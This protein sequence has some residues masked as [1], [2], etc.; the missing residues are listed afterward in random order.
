MIDANSNKPTSANLENSM[1]ESMTP[2]ER[3]VRLNP[4]SIAPDGG[5]KSFSQQ[6]GEY[7]FKIESL[8]MKGSWASLSTN[9]KSAIV[10]DYTPFVL[11][12]DCKGFGVPG[13]ERRPLVLSART[14]KHIMD[15]HG[16]D[17]ESL[18]SNL[19]RLSS[20][21][22]QNILACV[23]K[24]HEN[25]INFILNEYSRNGNQML[26]AVAIDANMDAIEVSSIRSVHGNSHLFSD[27]IKSAVNGRPFFVN[28]RTG[29]WLKNQQQFGSSPAVVLRRH[30]LTFYYTHL[31]AGDGFYKAD[32]INDPLLTSFVEN[33]D[34]DK[35]GNLLGVDEPMVKPYESPKLEVIEF[36]KGI[37]AVSASI[38]RP[39]AEEARRV[40]G[41]R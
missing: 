8:K 10:G 38:I 33:A 3:V 13:I 27:L 11:A 7:M 6:Y 25:H 18:I 31:N 26:T 2:L 34:R 1:S 19:N 39:C 24:T 28:E 4:H 17:A 12:W 22:S 41:D 37:E 9:A 40:G 21:M 14:L 30:L 15:K 32:I 20:E 36:E 35:Q 23:D 16:D 5:L 29:A